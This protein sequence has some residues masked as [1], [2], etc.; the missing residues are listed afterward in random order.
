MR[1]WDHLLLDTFTRQLSAGLVRNAGYIRLEDCWGTEKAPVRC[2]YCPLLKNAVVH[3][4][5]SRKP[6]LAMRY[7]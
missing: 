5:L 6:Q 4:P 7:L 2:S 1:L 3:L